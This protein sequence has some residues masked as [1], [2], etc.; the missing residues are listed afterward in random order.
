M[1]YP[2]ILLVALLA[3]LAA[4]FGSY[5]YGKHVCQGEQATVVADA[6]KQ[7]IDSANIESKAATKLAVGQIAREADARVRAA[8]IRRKGEI[9][10]IA[11]ARPECVRDADSMG[12]LLESIAAA[13]GQTPTSNS[14]S[15][16]LSSAPTPR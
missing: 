2:I 9:D 7:A 14:V 16:A 15:D 8:G 10:A 1:A 11:K 4:S 3:F 5:R 13:N 6:Q 12:L